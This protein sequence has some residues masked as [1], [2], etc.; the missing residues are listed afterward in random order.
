MDMK[1][2]YRIPAPRMQVWEALN[3]PEVLKRCIPGCEEMEKKS[4]TEMSTTLS[5]KVG[6]VKARF[7]GTI[8]LSNVDPGNSYTMVGEGKGGVA[9]FAKATVNVNLS[10]VESDTQLAYD[11]DATVGGKL[12]Q[13]GARLIDG[14][15]KKMADEFFSNFNRELSGEP[16]EAEQQTAAK[17]EKIMDDD[18]GQFVLDGIWAWGALGLA[19]LVFLVGLMF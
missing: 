1:G 5:A 16:E 8:E 3:D 19:G 13:V 11:V 14:T 6:P 17:N 4:D 7:Q 10:D 12:A 9:G 15:A 2:E 18:F